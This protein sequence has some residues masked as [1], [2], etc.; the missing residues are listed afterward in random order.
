MGRLTFFTLIVFLKAKRCCDFP[1]AGSAKLQTVFSYMAPGP[2][3]PAAFFGEPIFS[4]FCFRFGRD[5][6]FGWFY[7]EVLDSARFVTDGP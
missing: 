1:E 2:A 6:P 3:A 7:G 4:Y 5:S